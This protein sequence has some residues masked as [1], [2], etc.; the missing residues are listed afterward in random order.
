MSILEALIMVTLGISLPTWDVGSDIALA[1]SLIVSKCMSLEDYVKEHDI[2]SA[3][4][5][6]H[7]IGELVY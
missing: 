5:V 6:N 4:P 7:T 1:Y 2:V 3:S